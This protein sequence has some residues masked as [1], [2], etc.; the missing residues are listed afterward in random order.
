MFARLARLE[1]A[2]RAA[3][4]ALETDPRFEPAKG[5]LR[6]LRLEPGSQRP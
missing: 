3:Q 6:T 4:R 1:E 2:R 5:P